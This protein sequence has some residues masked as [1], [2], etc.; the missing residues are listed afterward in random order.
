M[1]QLCEA[2]GWAYYSA[3]TAPRAFIGLWNVA[4]VVGM[5][6]FI[7]LACTFHV[8]L[9]ASLGQLGLCSCCA[10]KIAKLR[11]PY[12]WPPSWLALLAGW[13][14]FYALL[15]VGTLIKQVNERQDWEEFGGKCMR[16]V[17]DVGP[18]M[19]LG[20]AGDATVVSIALGVLVVF[21]AN[22]MRIRLPSGRQAHHASSRVTRPTEKT[23]LLVSP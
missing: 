5:P 21:G 23:A 7:V 1:E 10:D 15:M 20:D 18:L 9:S 13:L 12:P 17:P 19:T 2:E 11:L 4:V 6:T 8:R 16:R 14:G 3:G 22:M